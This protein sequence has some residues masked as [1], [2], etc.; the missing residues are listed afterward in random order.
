MDELRQSG[1]EVELLYDTALFANLNDAII[2][3]DTNWVLTAWNRA[4]EEMFGWKAEEVLGRP[5]QEV[6]P[7]IELAGRP[8]PRDDARRALAEAGRF[9]GE[10]AYLRRDGR[11]VDV[12][13][14]AITL[15]D[16]EGA[17]TGYATVMR[18]IT[19]RKRWEEEIQEPRQVPL[20]EPQPGVA[21]ERGWQAP[22]CQRGEQ[23]L[24]A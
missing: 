2:A 11:P 17:V 19:E 23:P 22:L 6:L 1:I 9:R 18:D 15:R 24:A 3:T 12:E 21:S 13:T 20:R 8:P 16:H 14:N 5:S 4:A 10:L 7:T